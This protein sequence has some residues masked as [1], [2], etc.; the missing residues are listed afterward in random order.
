MR[1]KK[2]QISE[3]SP[4]PALDKPVTTSKN[5]NNTSQKSPI[6]FVKIHDKLMAR[7][8]EN[9]YGHKIL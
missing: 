3:I 8:K 7:S 9:V 4:K 2:I 5:K 6:G 1:L